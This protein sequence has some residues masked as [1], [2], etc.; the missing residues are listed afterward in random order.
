MKD[1]RS[2][3]NPFTGKKHYDKV[4]DDEFLNE[5]YNVYYSE[6]KKYQLLDDTA[7]GKQ[8]FGV[9]NQLINTVNDYLTKIGRRDYVDGYYD[10]EVHL[11]H[12]NIENACCYPGGKII[13]YSQILKRI[14][15]EEEIA[16]ILSHEI[17][18]ALLDHSRTTQSVHKR[19][20][21]ISTLAWMG[22]FIMDMLGLGGAG[23]MTRAAVNIANVGS[24]YFL[25]QPWGRD[26]ELEADK[27]GM[28]IAHLAGYDITLVPAF[29]QKFSSANSN[30]FDFFST[31]PSDG[32]RIHIMEET[33]NEVLSTTDYYSK[34]LLPETPKG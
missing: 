15:K 28:I 31:H 22:S 11:V 25:T 1:D 24:Q 21:N 17:S 26:H 5:S 27:L 6:V 18:H 32:K 30:E 3:L 23:N 4:N 14:E 16:F 9:A 10:W 13:V 20:N 12:S 7:V 29:W 33:L 8:L 34:P 19:K 2:P